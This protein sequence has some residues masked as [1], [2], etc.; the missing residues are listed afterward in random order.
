MRENR[1]KSTSGYLSIA[2]G[3]LAELETFLELTARFQFADV[4]KLKQLDLMIEE[5]QRM[6]RG[7][8]RSLRCKLKNS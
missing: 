4:Q 3:S 5:Q 8:Q 2:I 7:L 1:P 6:L